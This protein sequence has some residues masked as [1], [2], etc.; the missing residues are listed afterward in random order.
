MENSPQDERFCTNTAEAG[1][2]IYSLAPGNM[3][4]SRRAA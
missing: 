2:R 3:T 4:P 1:E